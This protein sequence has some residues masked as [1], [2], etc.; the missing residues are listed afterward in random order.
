MIRRIARY[1]LVFIGTFALVQSLPSPSRADDVRTY[2]AALLLYLHALEAPEQTVSGVT[3][4]RR[5]GKGSNYFYYRKDGER[6][7]LYCLR[8][9]VE[10]WKDAQ[11]HIAAIDVITLDGTRYATEIRLKSGRI[12]RERKDMLNLLHASAASYRSLLDD[13]RAMERRRGSESLFSTMMAG[14]VTLTYALLRWQR[15][16]G[17]ARAARIA[18]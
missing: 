18:A 14:I 1:T 6:H 8:C 16:V 17:R 15:R 7:Y 12:L 4:N 5:R 3:F 10:A 2:N 13:D 9:P 11:P